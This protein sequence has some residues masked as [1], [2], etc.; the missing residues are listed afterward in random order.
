MFYTWDTIALSE[1][2]EYCVLFYT[3][4]FLY[5]PLVYQITFTIVILL[6]SIT[7]FLNHVSR[8]VNLYT[9]YLIQD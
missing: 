1:Y 6:D 8:Y 4:E 7:Y 5:V 9:K 3:F 2:H